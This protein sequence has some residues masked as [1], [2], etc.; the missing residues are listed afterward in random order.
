[1]TQVIVIGLLLTLLAH[2]AGPAPSLAGALPGWELAL[3]AVLPMA[4][5]ALFA[6]AWVWRCGRAIDRTGSPVYVASAEGALTFVRWSALFLHAINVLMLGWLDVVRRAIGDWPML[7]ETVA[8][9]PALLTLTATWVSYAGIDA[10]LR[11]AAFFGAVERGEAVYP[12]RTPAQY[13]GDQVRGQLLFLLIP[14]GLVLGWVETLNMAAWR[15][16][17]RLPIELGSRAGAFALGALQLAGSI[18]VFLL[19]PTLL[20]RIWSTARMGPGPLRERLES[21]CARQGVRHRGLLVWRTHGAML[22]GAVM[23]IVG[24]LRY[25]LLTDAL[26]DHLSDSEV[27]AVLAHEL[28]HVRRRH[29]PWL[30][31]VMTTALAFGAGLVGTAEWA[32][33]RWGRALGI[34]VRAIAPEALTG[35]S[36]ALSVGVGLWLVGFVSRRF[37]RQA[38]A[39]A[40]Q[41]LSGLTRRERDGAGLVVLPEAVRTMTSALR[42]VAQRNFIPLRKRSW[43]H[44]SIADRIRR[45]HALEGRPLLDL[46]IDREVRII[47]RATLLVAALLTLWAFLG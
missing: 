43:R 32:L 46:P 19:A 44:G 8:M 6:H 28:G 21:L 30:M 33:A 9:L 7:D 5:L 42:T 34:D 12:V 1:M 10:R 40:V 41:H 2:D 26:L 11:Q 36:L 14:M 38:D 39:F 17:D 24:P 22:N 25:I 15:W 45:L 3:L 29:I 23:G 27:E 20:R 4:S 16:G 37:E 47:K 35:I 13:V 31:G 18:A